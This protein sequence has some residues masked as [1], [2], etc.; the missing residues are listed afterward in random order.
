MKVCSMYWYMP[1]LAVMYWYIPPS[2]VN[3]AAVNTLIV[4]QLD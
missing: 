1:P 2:V 3:P 4:E